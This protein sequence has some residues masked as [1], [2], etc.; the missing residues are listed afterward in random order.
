VY[1][2]ERIFALRALI[3]AAMMGGLTVWG[4]FVE[5]GSDGRGN[6]SCEVKVPCGVEDA[7]AKENRDR[8]VMSR[9]TV[10]D[11]GA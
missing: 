11:N 4:G 1:L 6:K 8:T 7:G 2:F 5:K 3:A 10:C 9:D